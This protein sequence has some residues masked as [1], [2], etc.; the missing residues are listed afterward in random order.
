VIESLAIPAVDRNMFKQNL[1]KTKEECLKSVKL[2]AASE[3]LERGSE[4][5]P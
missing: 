3:E 1:G 4:A 5:L 2:L